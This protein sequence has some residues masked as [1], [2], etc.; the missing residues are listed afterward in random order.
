VRGRLNAFQA[1]QIWEK[2]GI[3]ALMVMPIG[4]LMGIPFPTAL[5][6]AAQNEGRIIEWMWSVNASATV[7]GS[8]LA[9]FVFV[10]LGVTKGIIIGAFCYIFYALI[11]FRTASRS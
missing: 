5:R 4:V 6:L 7:F 10:T 2:L 11:L 8:V 9:V 1:N 3:T